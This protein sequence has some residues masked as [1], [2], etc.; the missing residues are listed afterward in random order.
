MSKSPNAYCSTK[1]ELPSIIIG[2]NHIDAASRKVILHMLPALKEAG[3]TFCHEFNQSY[4]LDKTKDFY[5]KSIEKYKDSTEDLKNRFRGFKSDTN[6]DEKTYDK[7][8]T[9]LEANITKLDARHFIELGAEQPDLS[10]EQPSYKHSLNDQQDLYALLLE[11]ITDEKAASETLEYLSECYSQLKQFE[12]LLEANSKLVEIF[13]SIG[14]GKYKNID[15]DFNRTIEDAHL[16]KDQLK[17]RNQEMIK[18]IADTQGP[19]IV[20]TGAAHVLDLLSSQTK[21]F[22]SFFIIGDSPI[23]YQ[24]RENITLTPYDISLKDL[25]NCNAQDA[26]SDIIKS[27]FEATTIQLKDASEIA[28]H[29]SS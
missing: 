10:A 15:L 7:L 20:L 8:L 3:Y 12:G 22:K 26:A 1:Q 13:D 24:D 11:H 29:I 17:E 21:K 6:L 4:D 27:L 23:P 14:A 5:N 16:F 2:E 19:V 25:N 18:N 28:P 9:L